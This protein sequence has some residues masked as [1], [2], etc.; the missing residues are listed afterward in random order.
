LKPKTINESP[1]T[2]QTISIWTKHQLEIKPKTEPIQI[3]ITIQLISIWTKHQSAIIKP[4]TKPIGK[5]TLQWLRYLA[6]TPQ[7]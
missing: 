3:H 4:K 1:I 2:I 5:H 6:N 7:D